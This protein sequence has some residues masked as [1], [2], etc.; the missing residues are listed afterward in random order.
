MT[1]VAAVVAFFA[2]ALSAAVQPLLAQAPGPRLALVVG[3]A[4]Y[5][6]GPLKT[7]ANDAALVA[8]TLQGAGFDVTG[9]AD[10]DQ[11]ALRRAIRDFLAKAQQAGPEATV[12]VYLAGYGVQYAGDNYFVPVDATIRR[13]AD[14]PVQAIRVADMVG[15]LAGL[16]LRARI[17]V[18]DGAR[19]DAFAQGGAPL[20]GGLA[21]VEPPPGMIYAL[22]AAPGTVAPAEPGPYG[23]YAQALAEMLRTGGVPLDTAFARVRLRVNALTAGRVVPW[24]VSTLGAPLVLLAP[25]PGAPAPPP[26]AP[27]RPFRDLSPSEAYVVAVERDTFGAYQEFLAAFPND[28]LAARVRMLLAARREAL[29]WQR[30]VAANTPNAYWTYMRRYPRGPH[31]ADARRR[32]AILS[33]ALEPPPRFDVYAYDGLPPP[34]E[35]DYVFVDRPVVYFDVDGPPPPPPPLYLLPMRDPDFDRLPPPA[36]PPERGFLPIPVPIP[37]PF[38]RPP[39]GAGRVEQPN[40]GQQQQPSGPPA[41]AAPGGFNGPRPGQGGAPAAPP[42]GA[43]PA[44]APVAP[45]PAAGAPALRPGAPAVPPAPAV[46]PAARPAAPAAPAVAP[47]PPAVAPA[48]R[49][50][51]PAA[52]P[53]RPAAPAPAPAPVVRQNVPAAPAARPAAPAAPPPAAVAPRPA[54]PVAR[55]AA[56]APRPEPPPPPREAAPRAAPPRP[57]EPPRPQAPARPPE[58]ARPAAPPRPPEPAKPAAPAKPAPQQPG[59]PD[60]PRP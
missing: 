27:P 42:A 59:R 25:A 33:A 24:D 32:L 47:A 48:A 1:K 23:V 40:F 35:T 52:A 21:L 51:A 12:F 10:L 43:P 37:I 19:A 13:D 58:P 34:P 14:V 50:A 46:A 2:L 18:L 57:P 28:P 55:P 54:P 20:A 56:P 39:G 17:F 38:G 7:T 53:V 41:G 60:Q 29:T 3:D 44:A 45:P 9:G 5:R 36:P 49:P 16:P 26:A 22:N 11:D 4:A 30:T 31:V 8:Q 15:A 6:D